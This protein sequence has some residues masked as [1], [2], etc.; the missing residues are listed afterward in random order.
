MDLKTGTDVHNYPVQVIRTPMKY[1][2]SCLHMV[3]SCANAPYIYN[4]IFSE[5]NI[6][7]EGIFQG[8][9]FEGE[10]SEGGIFLEPVR[11]CAN[12]PYKL[13]LLL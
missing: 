9:I 13:K 6:F 2:G 5:G 7:L 11:P 8:G 4:G 3:R 1:G 12:A 10:Y